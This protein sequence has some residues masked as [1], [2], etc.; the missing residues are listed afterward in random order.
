MVNSRPATLALLAFLAAASPAAATTLLV[1]F[2]SPDCGPCRGMRP[3]I[4]QLVT[5][6][7][8]VRHVDVST[9]M[10][11]AQQFRVTRWPTFLVLKDGVEQSRLVGIASHAQLVEMIRRADG[12]AAPAK[13]T[14]AIL[15][16][17]QRTPSTFTNEPQAGRIV[18]VQDPTPAPPGGRRGLPSNAA[19]AS[20][21][22]N[23]APLI[24]ATVRLTVAD[25]DGHSTGTGS[26]VDAR[27][28]EALVLTCGHLFRT[29]QGQGAIE[30]SLFAE[31]TSGAELQGKA[32]GVLVDYDLDRDLALVRFAT[33]GPV[34]VTPI[35]PP[36]TSMQ[37]GMGL[38]SVGC[39]N[40]DD[41]T[42]RSTQVT[43]IDRYVGHPNLEASGAPVEGRSGGGLF[44]DQGQLVGVCYAADP[45]CDEGLY[46][47]LPSIYAKLDSLGLS[48][49][50]REPSVGA[51][52]SSTPTANQSLAAVGPAA[53]PAADSSLQ[54]RG[55]NPIAEVA[56]PFETQPAPPTQ[57]T[58]VAAAPVAPAAPATA[59]S[60]P[61]PGPV[62]S[63]Q[64]QAI[65]DEV[66]RRGVDSEIICIIRPRGG[67]GASDVIK[68]PSA[69][70]G[71][72][73]AL[74]A[75]REH[76]PANTAPATASLPAGAGTAAR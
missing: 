61:M 64:E 62:L 50:Y 18:S 70:P 66:R 65:L 29:S 8:Q 51:T 36:G 74:A 71:L 21:A 4:E 52:A 22:S 2:T 25:P 35:A 26:I 24:A 43:A 46:A 6:G 56:S 54:I 37:P 30:L 57:P 49:I 7:Y 14:P 73:E 63:S 15:A 67:E 38:T 75:V 9:R 3:V 39:N 76:S 59:S 34:A 55:Q 19:D 12:A 27:E 68:I 41:P 44:N 72:I 42:P 47:S 11:L 17:N 60:P 45:E 31:G 48:K 5:E 53:N 20:A 33:N 58:P 16:S 28:G 40:G 69:S 23:T 10:Q 13:G 1:E 32:A